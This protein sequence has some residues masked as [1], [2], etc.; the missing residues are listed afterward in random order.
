MWVL[1]KVKLKMC[2]QRITLFEKKTNLAITT[3]KQQIAKMLSEKKD[4]NARIRIEGVLRQKNM[5][6]CVEILSLMCELLGQRLQLIVSQKACSPDLIE[7]VATIIYCSDRVGE[8]PE[9]KEITQQFALKYTPEWCKQH[10]NNE[11][12]CVSPRV[13]KLLSL[14]PPDI[15][16]VI[17]AMKELA[18]E[19]E[20]DWEPTETAEDETQQMGSIV[21]LVSSELPPP[22]ISA[23]DEIA[24][25]EH[26]A[27]ENGQYDPHGQAM[28][29]RNDFPG[30]F[31][32]IVHKCNNLIAGGQ[33]VQ[34]PYVRLTPRNAPP[35]T[36]TVDHQG[37]I[38]PPAWS[39]QQFSFD[40]VGPGSVLSVEVFNQD[41][42]GD[43]LVGSSEVL[44]DQHRASP[45][46]TAAWFPLQNQQTGQTSGSILLS[47]Q[48]LNQLQAFNPQHA[49]QAP[50][51]QQFTP[52]PVPVPAPASQFPAPQFPQSTQ[53][54]ASPA[55]QIRQQLAV[56]APLPDPMPEPAP[57]Y[58][59][60]N[61]PQPVASSVS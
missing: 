9:L 12:N 13:I 8:I 5:L 46:R 56:P 55:D 4:E 39:Q 10:L 50:M 41:R 19:L 27:K 16:V 22:S 33:A 36:T 21:P 23:Q 11:S 24:M 42:V 60:P 25:G 61:N 37:G 58:T 40:V 48:Y 17:K 54:V 30:V 29:Q 52:V 59:N 35:Q 49:E 1:S 31:R 3:Q 53:S 45:T 32:V 6:V 15:K 7:A 47:L 57:A 28:G 51:P 44:V 26:F 20:V 43:I 18:A 2:S 38:D 34:H 14:R